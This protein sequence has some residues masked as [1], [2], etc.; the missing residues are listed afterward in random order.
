MMTSSNGNIFHVTVHLWGESTGLRWIPLTKAS[1]AGLCC[2]LWSVKFCSG[3]MHHWGNDDTV[4][5]P[6]KQPW[7]IGVLSLVETLRTSDTITTK[8]RTVKSG[9]YFMGFTVCGLMFGIYVSDMCLVVVNLDKR[10]NHVVCHRRVYIACGVTSCCVTTEL[11]HPHLDK[12]A[13]ISQTIFSGAFS[14]I[15][16]FAFWLKVH[17]SLFLRV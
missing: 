16:N 1:D 5:M 9:A 3:S 8:Q 6:L 11:T 4:L 13:E 17:W 15:K 2:F 10:V 7:W 14:R 12:M